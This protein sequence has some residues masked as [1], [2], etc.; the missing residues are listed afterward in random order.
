MTNYTLPLKPRGLSLCVFTGAKK[1]KRFGRVTST[2]VFAMVSSSQY[3]L[4]LEFTFSIDLGIFTGKKCAPQ[5]APP[6]KPM[7]HETTT[8]F[9]PNGKIEGLAGNDKINHQGR[10]T[11]FRYCS[12]PLVFIPK[13]QFCCLV[14]L[15]EF[16][17]CVT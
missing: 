5:V 7:Q 8:A 1:K 6:K 13:I 10:H 11:V 4:E 2:A 16:R 3:L 15:H 17:I 14:I 12:L 9:I